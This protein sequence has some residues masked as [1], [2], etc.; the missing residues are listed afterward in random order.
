MCNQPQALELMSIDTC[1]GTSFCILDIIV[2]D[3]NAPMLNCPLPL[4]VFIGNPD[5]LDEVEDWEES[6]SAIDPCGSVVNF[7]SDLD[8]SR[9]N[10]ICLDFFEIPVEFEGMDVCGN[11]STCNTQLNVTNEFAPVVTCD[12]DFTVECNF[13][14]EELQDLFLE[15]FEDIP[16]FDEDVTV[17]TDPSTNNIEDVE[18]LMCG[19]F[20]T[21][22]YLVQDGCER[23]TDCSAEITVEDNVTPS[24]D[25]CPQNLII[26]RIDDNTTDEI[27]AW[28]DAIPFAEDNCSVV[29][30]SVDF[31]QAL[32]QDLCAWPDT[33]E[34]IFIAADRCGNST[35]CS[36]NLFVASSTVSLS[37]QSNL[38][39]EC[40]DSN[41]DQLIADWLL[42]AAATDQD[43]QTIPV[44]NNF[45]GQ[46]ETGGCVDSTLVS[47]EVFNDC[48]QSNQCESFI[49]IQDTTSPTILCP[50]E[51]TFNVS[52]G[53]EI[54]QRV[55]DW[56]ALVEGNDLCSGVTIT[57]T[58]NSDLG[59]LDCDFNDV[60]EFTV[61]DSC[62]LV[63]NC[64][65]ALRIVNDVSVQISCP[66]DTSILCSDIN[67]DSFIE[68]IIASQRVVTATS[69]VQISEDFQ[70]PDF[71]ECNRTQ[72][73]TINFFASDE[74]DNNSECSFEV[75][76]IPDP[77]VYIPNIFN[78]NEANE[79][80]RAFG[81]FGND[82]IREL[83]EAQVF[84]RY[85]NL[86]RSVNDI[87]SNQ[88]PLVWDGTI[89][90][91]IAEQGVY[92][93]VLRFTTINSD[94]PIQRAGTFTLL[95]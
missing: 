29:D 58:F 83:I 52:E 62:G 92:T 63:S 86:L 34:V 24:Q 61:I 38:I 65:V 42:L 64:E 80:N 50:T 82:G 36:S 49:L 20:V 95:R 12:A 3:D 15:Q 4:D 68:K 93:Y 44:T 88:I 79:A 19:E 73:V 1:G 94:I 35:S 32:L 21:V 59:N 40:G 43:G 16:E 27:L 10:F 91:K 69:D 71:D 77:S 11:V 46:I 18:G 90:G 78:L 8:D 76:F 30:N 31:D 60:V 13:D 53:G 33:I 23:R 37:C 9:I 57:N 51:Q 87:N 47:F 25:P 14:I 26:D 70:N 81:V 85:G 22:N 7:L 89:N 48:G 74:C 41:N 6:I 72:I 56:L 39:L 84:D 75:I 45:S 2:T 17:V 67:A 66:Q 55:E 5:H 28:L 54:S